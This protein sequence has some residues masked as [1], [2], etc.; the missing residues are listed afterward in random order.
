MLLDAQPRARLLEHVVL[1][2]RQP[3]TLLCLGCVIVLVIVFGFDRDAGAIVEAILLLILLALN[4]LIVSRMGVA[5]VLFACMLIFLRRPA[6]CRP[7]PVAGSLR[8]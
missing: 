6:F 4:V 2:L 1:Q 3:S 7:A 8:F 5:E